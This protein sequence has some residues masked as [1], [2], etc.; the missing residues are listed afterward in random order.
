MAT[1]KII[2]FISTRENGSFHANHEELGW[3]CDATKC[4]NCDAK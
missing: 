4:A 1:A 2:A 3:V